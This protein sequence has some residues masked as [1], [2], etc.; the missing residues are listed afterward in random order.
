MIDTK[1]LR[2][3]ILDLAIR[4]KLVPQDPKDELASELLKKIKAEKEALIKAG[5][6]K[7]DK[8]ESFIFRGDDNCYHENIDGETTD[9]SKEIPFDLPEGWAWCRLECIMYNI[10]T[11]DNQIKTG[12]ILSSGMFPVVSQGQEDIDGFCD[13]KKKVIADIPVVL[14]GDHTKKVKYIDFPF[15]VGADG[16]KIFRPLSDAKWLFYWTSFAATTIGDRGYGRHWNL[17]Q[18]QIV[19]LPPLAEQK[20]IVS[21]IEKLFSL[22]ETMRV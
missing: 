21:R 16:T 14:F 9:I 22:L 7:R 20:R 3:K 2:Q 18:T 13:S 19:P 11:K 1:L 4:G 12:N 6:L 17:L 5:K 10:R 8:H 15:V